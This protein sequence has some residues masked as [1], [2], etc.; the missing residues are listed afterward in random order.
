M[1]LPV[2][3][4]YAPYPNGQFS[5]N[6]LT[7]EALPYFFNVSNEGDLTYAWSVNSQNGSNAENP[8]SAQIT[9][10]QGTPSGTSLDVSLSVT[11]PNDSTV[12]TASENLTYENQL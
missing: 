1:V 12:G 8:E 10:P 11:N 6:P 2:A 3:V 5:N 7:V 4:L 9:L